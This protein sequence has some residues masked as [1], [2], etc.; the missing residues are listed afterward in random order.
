MTTEKGHKI[1]LF[2][3]LCFLLTVGLPSG[4]RSQATENQ[5]VI[6]NQPVIHF[7]YAPTK[8]RKGDIWKVYLSVSDPGANMSKVYFRIEQGGG[9]RFNPSFMMLKKG[10]EQHFAGYFALHTSSA[11]D[12]DEFSLELSVVD[13]K[14][15]ERVGLKFPF[16]IGG[17]SAKPPPPEMEKELNQRLGMINIDLNAPE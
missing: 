6:Q 13:R 5:P 14:G 9:K 7:S 4:S 15:S 2:L 12:G 1:Y 16:Q 3:I 17:P 10:M 8:V 11:D